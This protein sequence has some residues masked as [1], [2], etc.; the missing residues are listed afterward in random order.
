MWTAQEGALAK[1]QKKPTLA[2]ALEGR[3]RLYRQGKTPF[4]KG[5]K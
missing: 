4:P 1:R 3:M 2:E 5:A